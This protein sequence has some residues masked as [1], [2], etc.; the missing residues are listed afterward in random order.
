MAIR[1]STRTKP[2][3]GGRPTGTGPRHTKPNSRPEVVTDF[4]DL[5]A[6]P[7]DIDEGDAIKRTIRKAL[8]KNMKHLSSWLEE[9]GETDA[10]SALT[11]FMGLSEFVTSKVSRVDSV[12]D[13]KP[14]VHVNYE[15]TEQYKARMLKKQSKTP[16]NDFP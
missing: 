2:G 4:E 16:T 7:K 13:T 10:K 14:P 9:L 5:P 11:I 1:K 12:A 15:S 3:L 6:L 8:E